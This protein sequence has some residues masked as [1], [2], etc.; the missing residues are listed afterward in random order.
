MKGRHRLGDALKEKRVRQ[1]AEKTQKSEAAVRGERDGGPDEFTV[2]GDI[3]IREQQPFT[4]GRLRAEGGG[5]ALAGP[6]RRAGSIF[7]DAYAGVAGN[8]LPEQCERRIGASVE[9]EDE[10]ERR[11]ALIEE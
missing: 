2:E 4:A 9:N 3:G 8:F 10:F 11:I 7:D 6:V 5:I 1:G